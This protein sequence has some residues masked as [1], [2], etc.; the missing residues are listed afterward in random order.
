MA[1][2][3]PRKVTHRSI[4]LRRRLVT[5]GLVA[6]VLITGAIVLWPPGGTPVDLGP[7]PGSATWAR[8]HYGNPDAPNFRAK[9]IV[10]FDLL[11]RTMFVHRSALP[12]F[13]RLERLFEA[14]AP[15]YAASVA[16]GTLDDWSYHNRDVRAGNAKSNHAFGLAVDVNALSNVMGTTGDM[17]T[18]VTSQWEDEGGD[19]GGDWTRPDPMHFETQLTPRQIR[20]RY[21][22]D[23]T[24]R[25]WFLEQLVGG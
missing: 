2:V 12:H 4:H 13:L 21:L 5:G 17:P 19:W 18:E 24:P 22:P 11:G 9:K 3:A 20:K 1:L 15:E 8:K 14:R 6:A 10:S 7:D 16:A 25:D 23:G